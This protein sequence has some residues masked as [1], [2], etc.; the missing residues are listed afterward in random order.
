VSGNQGAALGSPRLF[1][2]IA[3]ALQIAL[4]PGFMLVFI[5]ESGDPGFGSKRGRHRSLSPH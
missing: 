5:D 3:K 4:P 1:L 2:S